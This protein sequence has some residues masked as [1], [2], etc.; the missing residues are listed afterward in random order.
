MVVDSL[1]G[2]V[3]SRALQIVTSKKSQT[4]EEILA[5][6]WILGCIGLQ[7]NA[8]RTCCVKRWNYSI[9]HIHVHILI[10]F[11]TILTK[12]CFIIGYTSC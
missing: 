12:Q 4:N 7:S 6:K 11:R 8:F 1:P 3:R 9:I 2:L 10:L 5:I